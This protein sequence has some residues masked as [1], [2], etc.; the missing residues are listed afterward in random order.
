MITGDNL[1]YADQ[2]V[3][4]PVG[5]TALLVALFFVLFSRKN[6]I[7][8]ALLLFIISIPSAQRIVLASLDFSFIRILILAAILRM[9]LRRENKFSLKENVDRFIF[10]WAMCST[11]ANVLLIGDVSALLTRSAYMIDAFGAYVVGRAYIESWQQINRVTKFVLISALP[12]AV[13]FLIERSTGKNLFSIFG[14]VPEITL[15][16]DGRLRC[17][18]PFSHPIMAGVFWASVLPWIAAA[19]FGRTQKRWLLLVTGIAVMIIVFNTASSTPVAAVILVVVGIVLFNF[20]HYLSYIRWIVLLAL[21]VLHFNMTKGVH[22]LLARIDLAGGST[23]WHRYSLIDAAISRV[24]EWW[25]FGTTSTRHWGWGLG[26]V[27]NQYVLEGVR[28]GILGMF[29]FIGILVSCFRLI[30]GAL[31][32]SRSIEELWFAWAGGVLTFMYATIFLA[33]SLFGQNV[34]AFFLILGGAVSMLAT[35]HRIR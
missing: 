34:A 1:S 4:H 28:G 2:T 5:L 33:V 6:N 26:D 9:L 7:I 12:I 14:G 8:I 27:T 15:V 21:I 3:V 35:I 23:G 32:N 16:R 17:Q 25:L 10:A 22:H 20:R 31:S 11:I 13:L 19:W 18:G 30:G 29:L 24:G